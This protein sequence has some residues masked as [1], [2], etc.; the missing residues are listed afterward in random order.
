[1]LPVV[2]VLPIMVFRPESP[3]WLVSQDRNEEALEALAKLR[4]HNDIGD[5]AVAAELA[6]IQVIVD[7]D[8]RLEPPSLFSLFFGR[9]DRR[10]TYLGVG[11]LFLHELAG[12][13][14]CLYYAPK[15]FSQAGVS[16]TQASLLANAINGALLL[17]TTSVLMW[18]AD[19][20]GRRI[21]MVGSNSCTL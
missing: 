17:A 18:F 19:I 14:I 4:G 21:Q 1:M 16:D 2:V 9:Q 3:H 10:R 6:E 5:S 12:V 13:N 8:N 15:V 7:Y 11:L 20:L